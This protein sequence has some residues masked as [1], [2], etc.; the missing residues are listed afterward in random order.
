MLT[1]LVFLQ[2]GNVKKSEKKLMKM[3]KIEKENLHIFLTSSGTSMRFLDTMS[4]I[5]IL[6][7]TKKA[8][9]HWS[10]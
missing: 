10:N 6:K 1:S 5:I 3:V 8:G 2:Q 7:V 9:L 4:L